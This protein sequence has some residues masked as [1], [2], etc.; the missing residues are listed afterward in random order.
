M[1][2]VLVSKSELICRESQRQ[3]R[4]FGKRATL[5]M[6]R[7][8]RRL[9]REMVWGILMSQS[10]RLS[11]IAGWIGGTGTRLLSRVKRLSRGLRG[12]L[13]EERLERNHLHAMGALVG[14]DS[15]VVLDIS[16]IQKE[17]GR[18][19]EYL[20]QVHDG[21]TGEIGSGYNFMTVTAVLGKG[22]QMPLYLAPYSPKAPEYESENTEVIRAVDTVMGVI[23]TKGVWVFDRGFDNK[24]L[25]NELTK[26]HL[27]FLLCAHRDRTVIVDGKEQTVLKIVETVPLRSYLHIGKRGKKRGFDIQYGAC[28][29]E[30]SEYWDAQERQ[31]VKQKLWL[32]VVRGYGSKGQQT[33]FYTN[34]PLEDPDQRRQMVRRYGDRWAVEE[35]HEFLKQRLQMEDVRVRTWQAIRRVC[36][37][38]ML[39][40][41]FVAWL[42]ERWSTKRKRLMPTLCSTQSELDPDAAFIY[43]RVLEAMQL[44]CA[45]V[46]ALELWQTG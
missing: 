8:Q 36:L 23:G 11:K 1:E 9:V 31:P 33:F 27:R 38:L 7:N 16:D 40:F 39:A 3:Y 30:L 26:R 25:F 41:A 5:G 19:F 43:Y 46:F 14:Q 22:R 45:F 37:C 42:V 4:V 6:A 12:N 17:R 34:V 20:S 24:W 21:S 28:A 13:E 15:S 2:R 18:K 44:A 29:L 32:L 35:E 10:V